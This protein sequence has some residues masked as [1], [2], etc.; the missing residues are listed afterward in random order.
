M[1][2][3]ASIK[4]YQTVHTE[5]LLCVYFFLQNYAPFEKFSCPLNNSKT[6]WDIF[7]KLGTNIK[8]DQ[9]YIFYGVMPFCNFKFENGV[10]YVTLNP[11]KRYFNVTWYK[12]KIPSVDMKTTMMT[13]SCNCYFW[14][15]HMTLMFSTAR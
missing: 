10:H 4:Y 9:A 5:L 1:K 8:H 15:G 11:L 6:H 3:D 12:Y 7:A 2:Q 14:L 13:E